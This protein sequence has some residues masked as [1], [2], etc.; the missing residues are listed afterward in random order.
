MIPTPIESV[1]WLVVHG[2]ASPADMDIGRAEL[3]RRHMRQGAADIA[4]HYVVRR[5]GTVEKGLAT[6]VP[7]FHAYGYNAHSLGICIVGGRKGKTNRSENN[8]TEAQLESLKGLLVML[9]SEH[10]G[11]EVVAHDDLPGVRHTCPGF[12]VKGWYSTRIA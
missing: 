1:D 8:Y 5:D 9:Q 3:R 10:A 7:G 2:S 6:D 12:D 4:Y 11:S